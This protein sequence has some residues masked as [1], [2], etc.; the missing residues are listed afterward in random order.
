VSA[1]SNCCFFPSP[2][3]LTVRAPPTGPNLVARLAMS[4][5][6]H[7]CGPSSQNQ[8]FVLSTGDKVSGIIRP[9]SAQLRSRLWTKFSTCA[10]SHHA[11][12][13]QTNI[14]GF[15]FIFRAVTPSL[16]ISLFRIHSFLLHLQVRLG[17]CRAIFEF[18][19]P[20]VQCRADTNSSWPHCSPNQPPQ[21]GSSR[22]NS[23]RVA[24]RYSP[25]AA[26]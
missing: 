26:R 13:L 10:E 24:A 15:G 18:R 21:G 7:S 19:S 2:F 23:L 8:I 14:I 25:V 22:P 1:R 3:L 9:L 16:V 12:S 20:S 17:G 11:G 5:Q 4:Q 6:Q